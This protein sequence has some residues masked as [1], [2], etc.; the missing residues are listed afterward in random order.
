M[1]SDRPVILLTA[2][3]CHH[4]VT[5]DEGCGYKE[6]YEALEDIV[7]DEVTVRFVSAVCAFI[8]AYL[9]TTINSRLMWTQQNKANC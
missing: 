8:D 6:P 1:V 3:I 7:D 9:E 4:V 2:N 5:D